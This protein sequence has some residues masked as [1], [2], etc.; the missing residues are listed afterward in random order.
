MGRKEAKRD[1][2]PPV[3]AALKPG[4]IVIRGRKRLQRQW[5]LGLALEEKRDS[6]GREGKDRS[7]REKNQYEQ[8]QRFWSTENVL[9]K[10]KQNK[11]V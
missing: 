8:R 4:P 3:G 6:E 7:C 11:L 10:Q 2:M 9:T 5:D 1:E